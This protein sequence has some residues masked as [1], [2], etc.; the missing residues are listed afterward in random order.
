MPGDQGHNALRTAGTGA[1]GHTVSAFESMG[2]LNAIVCATLT[3]DYGSHRALDHLDLEVRAGEIFGYLGSNGAGKTTTIRCLL[4]LI[5]PSDGTAS[6]LGLDS[7]RDSVEVR[8]RT[9]YLPGDLRV[10][11]RLTAREMLGYLGKLR[12]GVSA[13]RV[14]DLAERLDCDLTQRCGAMSHGQRQKVG[15]IQA[16]MHDP[17]VLVL[18]EPTATLDPLMQRIVHDLIREARDG[19]ATIFVSSHDLPE[20]AHLCDRAGILRR[21]R[22]VTVL[23]VGDLA[24]RGRH[25]IS[26]QFLEPVAPEAFE[27]LPGVTDV[28]ATDHTVTVTVSGDLDPVVKTAARYRV[29]DLHSAEVDLDEVFRD[30]YRPEPGDAH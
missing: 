18:D 19:G 16:F 21:G 22:L 20:I 26:I 12:G 13:Q 27:S 8:R 25:V 10:W 15:V 1:P 4:D 11:S 3:K 5:R 7:R 6:V 9:G 24:D 17:E 2:D 30:Y 28:S 23:D 14:T 29:H